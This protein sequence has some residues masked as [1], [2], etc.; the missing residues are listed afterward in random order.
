MSK[1]F[2][3]TVHPMPEGDGHIVAKHEYDETFPLARNPGE[4]E[5]ET[6]EERMILIRKQI[7]EMQRTM[8]E[9]ALDFIAKHGRDEYIR[10]SSIENPFRQRHEIGLKETM[11]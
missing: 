7:M 6:T 11:Q 4:K 1:M 5:P 3:H 10:V 2:I 9:Q 8:I